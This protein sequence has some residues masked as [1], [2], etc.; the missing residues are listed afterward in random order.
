MTTKPALLGSSL[1]FLAGLTVLAAAADQ[2][3]ARAITTCSKMDNIDVRTAATV[4][5]TRSTDFVNVP[6]TVVKFTVGGT[7]AS[8]VL[9]RYSA[10]TNAP[11]GSGGMDVKL[12]LDGTTDALPGIVAWTHDHGGLGLSVQSFE[13]I[14]P[15]V[16]PGTH[17]ARLQWRSTDGRPVQLGKRTLTV[18]H[19]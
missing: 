6:E 18:T 14:Y 8:C 9:V 15:A 17:T 7:A 1:L 12:V 19:Q 2:S 5:R 4:D 16:L 10:E 13:F 3:G 11:G